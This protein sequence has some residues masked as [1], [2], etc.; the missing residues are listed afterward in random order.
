M[1][2]FWQFVRGDWY[3]AL[4]LF[5]M[6]LIA[7]TLVIWRI[8]LNLH[9]KTDM[10]EFLPTFQQKLEKEGIDAALKYCQSRTD[11]IP[12]KLFVAGLGDVAGKACPPCGEPW[13]T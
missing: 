12:R 8:M 13:P 6:S 7:L 9:A 2:A 3:F 4:P 11:M 5:L 10:S 1:S